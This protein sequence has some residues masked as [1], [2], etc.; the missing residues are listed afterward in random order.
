MSS[1]RGLAALRASWFSQLLAGSSNRYAKTSS[2]ESRELAKRDPKTAK[3]ALGVLRRICN[4]AVL[5]GAIAANPTLVK[6]STSSKRRANGFR[7]QPLTPA[8]IGA[9]HDYVANQLH[10]PVYALA[11]LFD[12]FTGLRAAEL[13]G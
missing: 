11:I 13:A 12:A 7:H 6:L 4:V 2:T 3:Q 5:D 9:L 1:N 10:C 8:Q